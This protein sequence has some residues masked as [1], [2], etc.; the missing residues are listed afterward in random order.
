MVLKLQLQRHGLPTY[1]IVTVTVFDSCNGT[2]GY[3]AALAAAI[4]AAP[5]SV[6]GARSKTSEI[7]IAEKRPDAIVF[8]IGY[9]GPGAT[10]PNR[11]G[12]QNQ[13]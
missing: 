4:A 9:T 10:P 3:T 5:T 13:V 11:N 1:P 12:A 6:M 7:S 2:L 8:E